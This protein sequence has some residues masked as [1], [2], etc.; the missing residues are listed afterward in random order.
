MSEQPQPQIEQTVGAL[1]ETFAEEHLA[2]GWA[3]E[4]SLLG[5]GAGFIGILIWVLTTGSQPTARTI[6]QHPID[7]ASL[8]P[9]LQWVGEALAQG[10]RSHLL[11]GEQVRF[12]Q[13]A[14]PVQV[15]R[16]TL[17]P[18]ATTSAQGWQLRSTLRQSAQR[19]D[20]L[21]VDIEL[22]HPELS[23]TYRASLAGSSFALSDLA[24][25]Y[26]QQVQLWMQ[27]DPASPEAQRQAEAEIPSDVKSRQWYT[28]GLAALHKGQASFATEL[29]A[30][31]QERSPDHALIQLA[32][33]EAWR[34]LGYAA[35]AEH[36]LAQ[37]YALRQALSK[38]QR[39]RIEARYELSQGNTQRA[40]EIYRALWEFYPTDVNYG[41]ALVEAQRAVGDVNGA[42]DT[43]TQL[44]VALG[45]AYD[46]RVDLAYALL[47]WQSGNWQLGV[48]HIDEMLAKV[49]ST[50]SPDLAATALRHK[51]LMSE[52]QDPALLDQADALFERSNNISGR[53]RVQMSRADHDRGQGRLAEAEDRYRQAIELATR[54]GSEPSVAQGMSGLAIVLDLYGRLEEGIA[55]KERVVASRE[56]RGAL[57][58]MRAPVD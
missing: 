23:E 19:A 22:T 50:A 42:I 29:L 4:V 2:S 40:Q 18:E 21:Q 31:A 8:D 30:R 41:L 6:N 20:L 28:E 9:A 7:T 16:A 48:Q 53:V 55:W 27:L 32:L 1:R 54:I 49:D 52:P 17:L 45:E 3:R 34:A 25:R 24:V 10:V 47:L 58:G 44:R 15:A 13:S 43:I 51:F 56:A 33:G 12:A 14:E 35:K 57:R 26:T 37:A 36:H 11:A 38:E 46:A 39:L 5:L